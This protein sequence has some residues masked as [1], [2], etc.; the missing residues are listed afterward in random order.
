MSFDHFLNNFKSSSVIHTEMLATLS[1]VTEIINQNKGTESS[2]EYFAALMTTLEQATTK[3]SIAACLALLQMVLKSVPKPVLKLKFSETGHTFFQVLEKFAGTDDFLVLR[4]CIGC[5]SIILRVQDPSAWQGRSKFLDGI[6]AFT[7]HSKPKVRKAS[8]HAICRILRGSDLMKDDDPPAHHPAA[9]QVAEHCHSNLD[10]FNKP[11]GITTTLHVL[12]LL[13]DLLHQ[14]PSRFVKSI[15]EKLLKIMTMNDLLVKSCSLQTFH[16]LFV[17]Q[18]DENI[19][20]AV[21]NAQI[22]NALYDYQPSIGDTQPTLAWLAVMQEAH[23]NLVGKN[24]DLC[25]ANLPKIIEKTSGLWIS[26]KTEVVSAA[27]HTIKTLIQVCMASMCIDKITAK[28]YSKQLGKIIQQ[29]QMGL[30]YQYSSAWHHVLHLIQ[31]IF[32]VTRDTCTED[33]LPIL[34]E[35]A[36]LRDSHKFMYNSD[37]ESAVGAA[38]RS[39]GPQLVLSRIPLQSSAGTFDLNRSWLL[40]VL[41]QYINE[42][43]L[44]YFRDS[45]LPIAIMCSKKSK[46]LSEKQDGIGAH[47]YELLYYQIWALLPAFCNNP[48]DIKDNFKTLAQRLGQ[49]IEHE[50]DLRMAVMASIR[51]LITRSIENEA[52]EDTNE[53]AR[54][55]KN[56]L[57]L[58]FNLY[59]TKPSGSDDEGQR[60]SA[61]ETIV[62]YLSITSKEL[63]TQLFDKIMEKLENTDTDEYTKLSLYDLIRILSQFTDKNKLEILYKMCIPKINQRSRG[64]LQK[65]SYRIIEDICG[66]Q[67]EICKKYILDNRDSIEDDL[68]NAKMRI[69]PS[70]RS[71]R[72]RCI[73]NLVKNHDNLQETKFFKFII[74][75]IILCVKDVNSKCRDIAYDLL[76]VIAIKFLSNPE[77]F[78]NYINIII[79]RLEDGNYIDATLLALASIVFNHNGSVGFI[80]IKEILQRSCNL[81]TVEKRETVLSALSFIKVFLTSMPITIIGPTLPTI[82]EGLTKMTEDCKGHF[83]QKVRILLIKLIRKFGVDMITGI[84]PLT[85]EIM[86]KQLKNIRKH[87]AR[88]LKAKEEQNSKMDEEME[89]DDEFSSK[90][91]TTKS[92][93]DILADSDSEVDD[94]D[95]DAVNKKDK[96][97]KKNIKKTWIQETG[98][99][100]VDLADASAAKNISATKPG[101][102]KITDDKKS[103]DHGFKLAEDGRF[104]IKDDDDD[105]S[106]DGNSMKKKKKLPFLGSDSEDDYEEA[107]DNADDDGK[108]VISIVP[109]K[110]KRQDDASSVATSRYRAGGSGIHRPTKTVKV[111]AN[112]GAEYRSKKAPG[113][114][115]KKGKHD[116]YAYVPLARS[117]LNKRCV[118]FFSFFFYLKL[119]YINFFFFC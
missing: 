12:T 11:G 106:D 91:Q 24:V 46:E 41:K 73:R 6:L 45:M 95:D 48:I 63:I 101:S 79:G 16:S 9:S 18:P 58:L 52:K 87:E 15:C 8:Q 102:K 21:L 97:Q 105:D 119:I 92:I 82:I 28:K 2:T 10:N 27:T 29:I 66:S 42:S 76:D 83:R 51:K 81:L 1:A 36:D 60:R 68:N 85:N 30:K 32:L 57:P 84:V 71:T 117:A 99:T 39:L 38:V 65:K 22:I 26:D 7:I 75:E 110:R 17:S 14:F 33:I 115:K 43:T 113:D 59:T 40:P 98:D 114:V 74:P 47:S 69:A 104:I 34:V 55:A 118:I 64:K 62:I 3:E 103:K 53:L 56:Y 94:I 107:D 44:A 54:F 88:K 13:K 19:L 70:A 116:P 108:S 86:H 89:E 20:P 77:A 100:I 90:K 72:L 23:C 35:L 93:E 5:L 31:E 78:D 37:V 112:P 61:F 80:K 25:A 111:E 4:H 50:K 96:H 109:G 49:V 67:S